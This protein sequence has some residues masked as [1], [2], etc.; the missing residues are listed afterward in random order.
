MHTVGEHLPAVVR[1]ETT[2]LEHMLQDNMLN[3]YYINALG[4]H[5]YT[6]YLARMVSQ[7]AHSKP[8]LNI[9]EIGMVYSLLWASGLTCNRCWHWRSDQIDPQR[10]G[11]DFR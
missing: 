2:I 1:G 5:E 6:E 4:F 10:A 8:D 3:D 11:P 9:L 7:I